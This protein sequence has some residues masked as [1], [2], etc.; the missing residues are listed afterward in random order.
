MLSILKNDMEQLDTLTT[1]SSDVYYAAN[2]AVDSEDGRFTF[3]VYYPDDA[4]LE[5]GLHSYVNVLEHDKETGKDTMLVVDSAGQILYTPEDC[6][7]R[8]AIS[9]STEGYSL[10][11]AKEM[12][13]SS[14]ISELDTLFSS[15]DNFKKEAAETIKESWSKTV[16]I[17]KLLDAINIPSDI[18]TKETD[19]GNPVVNKIIEIAGLAPK[20]SVEITKDFCTEAKAFLSSAIVTLKRDILISEKDLADHPDKGYSE[21]K[22]TLDRIAD[23]IPVLTRFEEI[24]ELVDKAEGDGVDH[25][26][27]LKNFDVENIQS[28]SQLFAAFADAKDM[29][30]YSSFPNELREDKNIQ[31]IET[32]QTFRD[33]STSSIAVKDFMREYNASVD[34]PSATNPEDFQNVSTDGYGRVYNE[35]GILQSP[36]LNAKV[37]DTSRLKTLVDPNMMSARAKDF[38]AQIDEN[39]DKAVGPLEEKLK[40]LE[41]ID[42]L[43]STDSLSDERRQELEAHRPEVQ[44]EITRLASEIGSDPEAVRSTALGYRDIENGDERKIAMLI[45]KYG[46]N[47]LEQYEK[48]ERA[49]FGESFKNYL[50]DKGYTLEEIQEGKV[51]HDDLL[52]YAGEMID[53]AVDQYNFEN[54]SAH[55]SVREYLTPDKKDD[56]SLAQQRNTITKII[57]KVDTSTYTNDRRDIE[58]I[59]RDVPDRVS[60]PPKFN[61]NAEIVFRPDVPEAIRERN[62]PYMKDLVDRYT[63]LEQSV[64]AE[65]AQYGLVNARTDALTTYKIFRQELLIRDYIKHGGAIDETSVFTQRSTYG[66]CVRSFLR[67][68]NSNIFETLIIRGLTAICEKVDRSR[69]E[70]GRDLLDRERNDTSTNDNPQD[71]EKD[72]PL[73]DTDIEKLQPEQTDK[74]PA[75][76]VE[77]ALN[78]TD[79]KPDDKESDKP[80]KDTSPDTEKEENKVPNDTEKTE[81]KVSNDTDADN[82]TSAEEE[83]DNQNAVETAAE[84]EASNDDAPDEEDAVS[85][86]ENDNNDDVEEDEIPTEIDDDPTEAN[87]DEVDI[88]AEGDDAEAVDEDRIEADDE[89]PDMDDGNVEGDE[90]IDDNDP[91]EPDTEPDDIDTKAALADEPEEKNDDEH[92]D[93]DE[94]T[95]SVDKTEND[96]DNN[97]PPDD[98]GITGDDVDDDKSDTEE[99]TVESGLGNVTESEETKATDALAAEDDAIAQEETKED[100]APE[101]DE[102]EAI[103]KEDPETSLEARAND[104]DAVAVADADIE[105]EQADIARSSQEP[106]DNAE[107][108]AHFKD[109]TNDMKDALKDGMVDYLSHDDK[110][111]SECISSNMQEVLANYEVDNIGDLAQL[112]I[113]SAKESI[114][115]FGSNIENIIDGV[116]N[117]IADPGSAIMD[118]GT[119][120][121][122][123]LMDRISSLGE[124]LSGAFN[125]LSDVFNTVKDMIQIVPE[126]TTME[127]G[128]YDV[129]FDGNGNATI[130]MPPD[131]ADTSAQ[132]ANMESAVEPM[133]QD[134]ATESMNARAADINQERMDTMD[135]ICEQLGVDL[136][137]ADKQNIIQSTIDNHPVEA[138]I[139]FSSALRNEMEAYTMNQNAGIDFS[140]NLM[141]VDAATAL[142]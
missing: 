129:A 106:D 57:Q 86:E 31:F 84:N 101:N 130:D 47:G 111:F 13:P 77:K 85:A 82:K 1:D 11:Y 103:T 37:E 56:E 10:G 59:M 88:D 50:I 142:V 19:T 134:T 105:T 14:Y 96:D 65:S 6:D 39:I 35:F 133:S 113:D 80:E 24:L 33:L 49:T 72:N 124:T 107:R 55:V 83:K 110:E 32:L 138:N 99:A 90:A 2:Q 61:R 125:T 3:Y 51:D 74:E 115:K 22:V 20:S 30:K 45:E 121:A 4:E 116:A 9:C 141:D 94:D 18:H 98:S 120:F 29:V 140:Q 48:F 28:P 131:T 46:S 54:P 68:W 126:P 41:D 137:E 60:P 114:D 132:Y 89:V 15:S 102:S 53:R 109:F 92:I 17:G 5:R 8:T 73:R 27:K 21:T 118:K 66:T 136:S 62:L 87:D 112:F 43:L 93:K 67:F 7:H 70:H 58:H 123:S 34:N 104:D 119:D 117:F 12:E 135:S 69:A 71:T 122:N 78:D 63:K 52:G 26:E 75:T 81:D 38:L 108:S 25:T 44:D 95:D 127:I 23:C 139:D 128:G 100:V 36:E 76:D 91:V 42:T 64:A 40:E 97:D 79:A 16:D